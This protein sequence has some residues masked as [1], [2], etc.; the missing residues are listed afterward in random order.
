[1]YA[2]A[3]NQYVNTNNGPTFDTVYTNNWF[4]SNGSNCRNQ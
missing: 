1:V 3:M 2:T 4:R